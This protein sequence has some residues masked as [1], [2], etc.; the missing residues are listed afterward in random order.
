MKIHVTE[1]RLRQQRILFRIKLRR[2]FPYR[3]PFRAIHMFGLLYVHQE[4]EEFSP[5]RN[6]TRISLKFNEFYWKFQNL[7]E[8][9]FFGIWEST[10]ESWLLAFGSKKSIMASLACLR[11][12]HAIAI[13]LL[14]IALG[15]TIFLF[16]Q[17]IQSFN[18][19]TSE[20]ETWGLQN[21]KSEYRPLGHHCLAR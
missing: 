13:I 15:L 2:L 9:L 1:G 21:L 4:R 8:N 19:A 5:F 11:T 6:F 10:P 12:Y 7:G 18:N 3:G 17:N 16:H 14:A 20:T